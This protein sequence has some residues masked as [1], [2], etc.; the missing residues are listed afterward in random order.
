MNLYNIAYLYEDEITNS[1]I[2]AKSEEEAIKNIMNSD[3]IENPKNLDKESVIVEKI[4][5]ITVSG[6]TYLITI[7]QK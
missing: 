5:E 7:S 2:V 3:Y 6:V 1:L 4:N